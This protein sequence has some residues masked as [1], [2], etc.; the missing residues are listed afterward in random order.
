MSGIPQKILPLCRIA[1]RVGQTQTFAP[2]V[3]FPRFDSLVAA[4]DILIL[5]GLINEKSRRI[6]RH[7]AVLGIVTE[8][9]ARVFDA[10]AERLEVVL[11]DS[12]DRRWVVQCAP[13][14]EQRLAGFIPLAGA[15]QGKPGVFYPAEVVP[16]ERRHGPLH[17]DA[18]QHGIAPRLQRT[19]RADE[20][21][22]R[23][24]TC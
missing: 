15:R 12:R 14:L 6:R 21:I 17:P 18:D 4:A 24:R 5:R 7:P 19:Q 16:A 2:R 8:P 20:I 1:D 9:I 11:F 13:T 3:V 23:K 10:P 22:R